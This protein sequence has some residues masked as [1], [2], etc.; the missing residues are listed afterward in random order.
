MRRMRRGIRVES[1][2]GA[3]LSKLPPPVRESEFRAVD[4]TDE[5]GIRDHFGPFVRRLHSFLNETSCLRDIQDVRRLR[6]PRVT[7]RQAFEEGY[8]ATQ[9]RHWYTHNA[10]GRSEAQFNVGMFPTYLRVG[11][12]FEFTERAHGEP[13]AVQAAYGGFR[14]A[15]GRNRPAF[16][17]FARENA[18]VVEWVPKGKSDTKFVP[19]Q[20]V[21]R[22]L[23]KP[24][25]SD[26]IFVGRLLD[27]N[28]D[29]GVLEDPVRLG[30]AMESVFKYLEP[31]W[32][33]TQERTT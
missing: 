18:I 25:L 26:W 2:R 16:E 32:E 30:E 7:G 17:R 20:D 24:K 19:T 31:L 4:T 11:L 21:L 9:P 33:E 29:A 1:R 3:A 15:L 28:R 27:R 8:F 12:G 23:L 10:G 13:Y 6:N 14:Q 5:E 22:W